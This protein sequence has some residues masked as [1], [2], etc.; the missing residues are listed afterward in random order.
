LEITGSEDDSIENTDYF[1]RFLLQTWRVKVGEKATS[2]LRFNPRPL[3][4][5]QIGDD[6]GSTGRLSAPTN[7]NGGS[8]RVVKGI[9]VWIFRQK[10]RVV[11][12]HASIFPGSHQRRLQTSG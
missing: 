9:G 11:S 2:G 6:I 4:E 12:V 5:S 1:C 3:A 7:R 8:I 10:Y